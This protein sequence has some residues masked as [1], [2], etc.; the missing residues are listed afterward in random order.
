MIHVHGSNVFETSSAKKS[1]NDIKTAGEMIDKSNL[2]LVQGF[3][4]K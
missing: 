4:Q 3:F 1:I 2:L